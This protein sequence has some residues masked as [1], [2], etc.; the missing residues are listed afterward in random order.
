MI[1]RLL[2]F[3]GDASKRGILTDEQFVGCL[4]NLRLNGD[5]QYLASGVPSGKVQLDYCPKT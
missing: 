2:P 1:C 5:L 4:R 3:V